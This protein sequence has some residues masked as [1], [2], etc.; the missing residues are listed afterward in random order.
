L[1]I[2]EFILEVTGRQ[3]TSG[4]GTTQGRKYPMRK[5]K[6]GNASAVKCQ[7]LRQVLAFL[8]D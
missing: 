3:N 6:A 4:V 5:K 2:L 1:A 7:A 8:C